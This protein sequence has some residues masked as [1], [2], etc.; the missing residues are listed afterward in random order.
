MAVLAA[1]LIETLNSDVDDSRKTAAET[2]GISIDEGQ[3][4]S[5]SESDQF[6]CTLRNESARFGGGYECHTEAK[7]FIDHYS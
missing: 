1:T 6:W 5:S 2:Y 3:P 7:K 4:A